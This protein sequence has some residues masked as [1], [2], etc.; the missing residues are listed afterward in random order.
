[1]RFGAFYRRRALRLLPALIVFVI[2]F[3]YYRVLTN[4]QGDNEPSSVLSIIFYYSNTWL[5]RGPT[6]PGLGH[7]WSLSVE[8]QFYLIWPV[9]LSLFFGLRRRL[10]PTVV[11]LLC[12]IA[13]VATRRAV[14]WNHGVSWLWLYT[15]LATR[16]DA[17]LV[18]CLLAQLWVRGRLPKRGVQVAGWLALGYYAYILWVGA[19]DPFLYRGGYTLIAGSIGVVL[20]AALQTDWLFNRV[21]RA[22]PLRAVG[23]VSYG[24][25]IWHLP[26]FYAVARYE[27]I[28]RRGPRHTLELHYTWSPAVATIV[29]LG[30]TAIATYGSWILVERPILRWKDRLE[31]VGRK[32]VE[33]PPSGRRRSARTFKHITI[34]TPD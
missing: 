14:L 19:G 13:V 22:R 9:C 12:A 20:L 23:R 4:M 31:V 10:T 18:G 26:I 24:L 25:Y 28:L 33:V 11:I 21:L 8:E 2:I 27:T 16:A 3:L 6:W 32:H 15:R 7:M 30:L 5:H 1:M 34:R 29:A 17:M